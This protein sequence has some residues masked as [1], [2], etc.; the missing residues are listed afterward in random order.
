MFLFSYCINNESLF[1]DTDRKSGFNLYFK[2]NC[3]V[4]SLANKLCNLSVSDFIG[5]FPFHGGVNK[6]R[7]WFL[8]EN[9]QCG[10]ESRLTS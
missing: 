8:P 1:L 9:G 2:S 10:S 5:L 7:F 6:H 3:I 4:L